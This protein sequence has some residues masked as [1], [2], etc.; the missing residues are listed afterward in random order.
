[1]LKIDRK[2]KILISGAVLM[3]L[4]I[5]I[6]VSV[7]SSTTSLMVFKNIGGS[8]FIL[9]GVI[10]FFIFL[11]SSYS[12]SSS[13]LEERIR[14]AEDFYE[15]RRILD[16][17]GTI[18]G[19]EKTYSAK[20]LKDV[21]EAIRGVLFRYTVECSPEMGEI[22]YQ[23][24]EKGEDIFEYVPTCYGLRAKVKEL[25]KRKLENALPWDREKFL[26]YWKGRVNI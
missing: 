2:W 12:R 23:A 26:K 15:L 14:S 4:G 6:V 3:L 5:M 8:I 22:I 21:I 10:V 18:R 9:Y 13:S 1:M 16:E 25:V 20:E 24:F 19:V 11:A 17:A 7:P